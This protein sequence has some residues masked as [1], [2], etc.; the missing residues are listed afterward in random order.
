ME[1]SNW[2]FLLS[3]V[4]S[5]NCV[6]GHAREIS[7]WEDL[8]CYFTRWV[9]KIFWVKFWP[10]FCYFITEISFKGNTEQTSIHWNPGTEGAKITWGYVEQKNRSLPENNS[11]VLHGF[12]QDHMI[13][14]EGRTHKRLEFFLDANSLSYFVTRDSEIY[15]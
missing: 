12:Q 6:D 5:D 8:S 15:L 4:G 9:I 13:D 10:L 14:W 3:I 11:L 2:L 7:K 1:R